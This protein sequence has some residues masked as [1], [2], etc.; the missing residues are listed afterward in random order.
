MTT[1]GGGWTVFQR[2]VDGS[3]NFK[4]NYN[5]YR[6]GFGNIK[7]EFWLDSGCMALK[8]QKSG[9]YKVRIADRSTKQVYCDMTTDG[10]GWTVFQRRVDGTQNF[11]QNYDAYRRGF[12]NIKKEFWLGNEIIHKLTKDGSCELRV[13]LEDFDN[14]TRY[15]LYKGFKVGD[16][17]S[18]FKLTLGSY[19]GNA[20]DSLTRV[21]GM[22]FSTYDRD[23]DTLSGGH[24]AARYKGNEL[25]HNLTS[26]GSCELRVDLEDF[27]NEKRYA[28]YKGFRVGDQKSG[29]KLTIG[30]YS[31]DAGDSLTRVNGMKFSTYD[32]DQ[33]T[34]GEN[35]AATYRG[36]FW[37]QSCHSANPNGHYFNG[38]HKSYANGINWYHWRGYYYSMKHIKMM[39]RCQ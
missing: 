23:Q 17:S 33:D 34:W 12:G 15:A 35:C 2:R 10:G 5:A 16:E 13:D 18:G 9:V 20:G 4:Q 11:T 32:R 36:G 24:C 19:S 6:K 30:S 7:K 39:F 3:Q 28:L 25:L 29:F 26:N 37:H 21:N 31:G 22:K 8:N 38:K 14:K 27:D 1:D